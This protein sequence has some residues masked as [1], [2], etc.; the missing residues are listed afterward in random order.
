LVL[1]NEHKTK[2]IK[3]VEKYILTKLNKWSEKEFIKYNNNEEELYNWLA[4]EISK[5]VK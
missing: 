3:D 5:S 2:D 1:D 4:N